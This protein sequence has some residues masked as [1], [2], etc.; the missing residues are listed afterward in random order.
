MY[1]AQ[2]LGHGGSGKRPSRVSDYTAGL[3]KQT[4]QQRV[5]CG[6]ARRH[7]GIGPTKQRSLPGQFV[8]MRS[9]NR[10]VPENR[11]AVASHLVG[12]DH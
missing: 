10:L 1:V 6:D 3:G 12:H 4:G 7:G 11:K 9:A 8:Q 2:Q 5:T